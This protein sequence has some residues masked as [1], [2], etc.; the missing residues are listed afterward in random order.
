M[1]LEYVKIM[2]GNR[3]GIKKHYTYKSNDNFINKYTDWNIIIT[4]RFINFNRF[5][6][7]IIKNYERKQV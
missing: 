3:F 7:R 2:E 6:I 5:G 4:T 1:V